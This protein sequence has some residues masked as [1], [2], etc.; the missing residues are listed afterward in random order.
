MSDFD[1]IRSL[2]MDNIRN[3]RKNENIIKNWKNE[4][5]NILLTTKKEFIKHINDY[6][7]QFVLSLAAA[8]HAENLIPFLGEDKRH[9]Q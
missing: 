3:N 9:Q 7:D 2:T 6:A 8:D 1:D 5:R 4:I